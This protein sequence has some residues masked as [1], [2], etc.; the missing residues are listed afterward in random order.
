MKA[1]DALALAVT[2]GTVTYLLARLFG[3]PAVARALIAVTKPIEKVEREKRPDA[4][5]EGY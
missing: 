2:V 5:M 4:L 1:E 3:G